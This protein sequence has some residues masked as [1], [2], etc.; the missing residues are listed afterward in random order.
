[1]NL[2][3][4]EETETQREIQRERGRQKQKETETEE[5]DGVGRNPVLKHC[6]PGAKMNEKHYSYF[7]RQIHI[8]LCFMLDH[9]SVA[10]FQTFPMSLG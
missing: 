1:M 9:S 4:Q 6:L 5:R 8:A 7:K 2:P 10:V 3:S